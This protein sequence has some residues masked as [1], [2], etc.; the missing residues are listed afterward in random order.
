MAPAAIIEHDPERRFLQRMKIRHDGDQ[1]FLDTLLLERAGEVVVI[2]H[3]MPLLRAKQH[4]DHV[5]SEELTTV[6]VGALT[7][8]L[9]LLLDLAHADRDL[10]RAQFRNRHGYEDRLSVVERLLRHRWSPLLKQRHTAEK[11]LPGSEQLR[12]AYLSNQSP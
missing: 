3:V 4:R 10:R 9:A 6:T 2:D 1:H 5:A 7:P 8:V 11:R 12:C